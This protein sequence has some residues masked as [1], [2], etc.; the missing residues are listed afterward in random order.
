M[1]VT[2]EA[3]RL[4]DLGENRG[5]SALFPID[6]II[7][8]IPFGSFRGMMR[9]KIILFM[10]I[11]ITTLTLHSLPVQIKV[12]MITLLIKKYY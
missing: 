10:V 12:I 8:I 1:W 11:M 3:D 2:F 5:R 4:V 6:F 7:I 9:I